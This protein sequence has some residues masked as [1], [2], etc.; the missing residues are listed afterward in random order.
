MAK[1]IENPFVIV[2]CQW[3][4]E[5]PLLAEPAHGEVNIGI[6]FAELE[7]D[8]TVVTLD[9]RDFPRELIAKQ[10]KIYN[11][12]HGYD[13]HD[14]F[15]DVRVVGDRKFAVAGAIVESADKGYE[16]VQKVS[17]NSIEGLSVTNTVSLEIRKA[18]E[19]KRQL[20]TARAA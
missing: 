9:K 3:H 1:A 12:L 11:V 6:T 8:D 15:T 20:E 7:I 18:F 13:Y 10:K 16:L 14:L 2:H 5:F 17:S 19:E 4:K